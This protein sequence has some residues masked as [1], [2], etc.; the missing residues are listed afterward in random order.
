MDQ[1]LWFSK[2]KYVC[3]NNFGFFGFNL[4]CVFSVV[5]IMCEIELGKDV[6]YIFQCFFVLLVNDEMVFCNSMKE[7]GIWFEQYVE[8]YQMIMLCNLVYMFC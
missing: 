1:K 8:L 2:R 4:M 5:F 3:V 7:L 6:G